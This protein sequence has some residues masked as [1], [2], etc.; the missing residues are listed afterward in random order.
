[1]VG[2]RCD[3]TCTVEVCAV[4]RKEGKML[5]LECGWNKWL[6]AARVYV[7]RKQNPKPYSGGASRG[8]VE[9][10]LFGKRKRERAQSRRISNKIVNVKVD[11]RAPENC[12]RIRRSPCS[13]PFFSNSEGERER[14][15]ERQRKQHPL[16]HHSAALPT[17]GD[18]NAVSRYECMCAQNDSA[19]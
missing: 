12:R 4:R 1:M 13:M 14:E 10:K 19:V 16:V 9:G 6:C 8:A 3:A 2:R 5:A 7:E 17:L 11:G 15:R 18:L